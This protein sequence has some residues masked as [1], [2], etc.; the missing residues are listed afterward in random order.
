MKIR[1]EHL[2]F[3]FLLNDILLFQLLTTATA[4]TLPSRQVTLHRTPTP[5]QTR[6][7]RSVCTSVACW[8]E[9]MRLDKKTLL[10]RQPRAPTRLTCSTVLWTTWTVP[11]CLL[12]FMMTMHILNIWLP[13]SEFLRTQTWGPGFC[14]LV[15]M[16]MQFVHLRHCYILCLNFFWF[17]GLT[18]ILLVFQS[19]NR[20]YIDMKECTIQILPL[21]SI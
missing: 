18:N 11:T 3:N 13:S 21:R 8:R 7:G 2:P 9:N 6:M 5:S 17:V 4:R 19:N 20:T 16:I 10:R 14:D 12:S 1:I 15:Y